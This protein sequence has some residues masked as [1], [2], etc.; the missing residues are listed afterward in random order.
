MSSDSSRAALKRS[1]PIDRSAH[2]ESSCLISGSLLENPMANEK[3]STAMLSLTSSD[4]I[5]AVVPPA[6]EHEAPASKKLKLTRTSASTRPRTR[7]SVHPGPGRV[8][9]A[10]EPVVHHSQKTGDTKASSQALDRRARIEAARLSRAEEKR[11]QEKSQLKLPSFFAVPAA[12]PRDQ[13]SRREVASTLIPLAPPCDV[14]PH[15]SD[16]SVLP[17]RHPPTLYDKLF[18][19]FFVQSGVSLAPT[20]R[21]PIMPPPKDQVPG[22]HEG[23]WP[24]ENVRQH[25]LQLLQ[26]SKKDRGAVRGKPIV[27]ARHLMEG[28]VSQNDRHAYLKSTLGNASDILR[29]IPLKFLKFYEDVRPPYRGTFTAN[30]IGG[31]RRLARNPFCRA[32]PNFNYDY[33]SEAE[34]V[35]DEDGEELGSGDEEDDVDDEEDLHDFLDDADAELTPVHSP[36]SEAE[37]V[38]ISSGICWEHSCGLPARPELRLY[39]LEIIHASVRPPIDPFSSAYWPPR[40]PPSVSISLPTQSAAPFVS[41]SHPSRHSPPPRAQPTVSQHSVPGK[42]LLAPSDLECFKSIVVGSD[43]SKIG[44]IE[45]L[46]KRLPGRPAAVIKATLE[47]MARRGQKGQKEADKRWALVELSSEAPTN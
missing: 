22:M 1:S 4:N 41:Q 46:K 26:L 35:E 12:G 44:L 42:R 23:R 40:S 21:P 25:L 9:D 43:L 14:A 47:T 13:K 20:S 5:L 3:A 7:E 36:F 30:P 32:L 16:A 24:I 17:A 6:M 28:L 18:P 45:V 39:R 10:S 37:L 19:A 11:R 2:S 29:T 27:S 34:W 33:D 15:E 8:G 31:P 38:P